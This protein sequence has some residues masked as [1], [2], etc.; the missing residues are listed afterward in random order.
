MTESYPHIISEIIKIIDLNTSMNIVYM[1]HKN[2]IF[3]IKK[4][5]VN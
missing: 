2:F 4:S 5:G 3:K 1:M